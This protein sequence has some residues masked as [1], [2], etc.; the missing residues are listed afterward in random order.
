MFATVLR[1]DPA[2]GAEVDDREQLLLAAQAMT[3]LPKDQ[4]RVLHLV[5]LRGMSHKAAASALARSEDAC[6]ALLARARAALMV[7]VTRLRLEPRQRDG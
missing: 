6:R 5:V 1:Q 7:E 2:P 3:R 4:Q